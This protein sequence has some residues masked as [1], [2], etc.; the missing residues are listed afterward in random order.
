MTSCKIQNFLHVKRFTRNCLVVFLTKQ[1]TRI[2]SVWRERDLRQSRMW[3]NWRDQ[4][5]HLQESIT[6]NICRKYGT[7]NTWVLSDTF[8]IGMTTQTLLPLCRQCNGWLIFHTTKHWLVKT[9]LNASHLANNCPHTCK[10]ANFYL[11]IE[12]DESFLRRPGKSWWSTGFTS[13]AL[14]EKSFVRKLT[15]LYESVVAIDASQPLY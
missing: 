9:W 10:N 2:M 12:T 1:K 8:C 11:F 7:R 3:S 13:D 14:V 4:S 6:I 15:N 5:C